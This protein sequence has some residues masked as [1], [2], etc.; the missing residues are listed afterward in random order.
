MDSYWRCCDCEK[1]VELNLDGE[2]SRCAECG[3]PRLKLV[4]SPV[5]GLLSRKPAPLTWAAARLLF[6]EMRKALNL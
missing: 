2:Q 6:A 3:S 5:S 1:I 4:L